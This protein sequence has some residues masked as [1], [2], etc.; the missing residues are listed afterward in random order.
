MSDYK[1]ATYVH[2]QNTVL[3]QSPASR[4][5][6]GLIKLQVIDTVW[7]STAEGKLFAEYNYVS[8]HDIANT[9]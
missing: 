2:G 4:N 7:G 1:Q 9:M 6:N 8:V 3:H 5:Q